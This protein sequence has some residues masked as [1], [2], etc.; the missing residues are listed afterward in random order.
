M[1]FAK[2]LWET[3]RAAVWGAFFPFLLFAQ[4]VVPVYLIDV[5]LTM[6][7]LAAR[8][9]EGWAMYNMPKDS[10]TALGAAIAVA[11]LSKVFL[12]LWVIPLGY[13]LWSYYWVARRWKP[14]S[15]PKTPT[16]QVKA[17]SQERRYC[18]RCK[19]FRGDRTYHCRDNEKCLPYY[20]HTCFWWTGGVW[21]HNVQAYVVFLFF[22]PVYHLYIFGISL[23]VLISPKKYLQAN[24][25]IALGVPSI[26][27][28][29]ISG[30]VAFVY[31]R[32]LVFWN[33]LDNEV[34]HGVWYLNDDGE[35]QFWDPKKEHSS[36]NPWSKGWR[37]NLRA[38]FSNEL[39]DTI[40]CYHQEE[41]PILLRPL[42]VTSRRANASSTGFES[43]IE[44]G[45]LVR[46]SQSTA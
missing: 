25:Y 19:I 38:F 36:T 13:C 5:R 35:A 27:A 18:D 16:K 23:W 9:D 3:L 7:V 34:D 33:I 14:V 28:L 39:R 10:G 29:L 31:I 40:E 11:V 12:L 2:E 1:A 8:D 42:E 26:L 46:R 22:L 44:L 24:V 43:D 45:T 20:D 21:L 15:A 30:G 6:F 32:H 17:H 41:M 37:A 4:V